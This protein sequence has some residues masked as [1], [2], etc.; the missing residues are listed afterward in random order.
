MKKNGVKLCKN[1]RRSLF[2]VAASWMAASLV[3]A[4]L[5]TITVRFTLCA[6]LVLI[7]AGAADWK[8]S[9]MCDDG[10]WLLSVWTVATF[11]DWAFDTL[12]VR[13]ALVALGAFALMALMVVNINKEFLEE[14]K[15]RTFTILPR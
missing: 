7:F 11:V 2:R 8:Y 1:L 13:G 3:D 12:V 15:Q 10:L 6:A 5:E 9:S 4:R 14:R